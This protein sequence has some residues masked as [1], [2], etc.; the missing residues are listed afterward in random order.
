MPSRAAPTRA[1]TVAAAQAGYYLATG[2]APLLSR[3]AFERVT[4]PKTEWWLVV[5]VAG[6]VDAIGIPL[7][8]AAARDRIEPE[9]RLT[10]VAAA[11]VLGTIDVVYVAR[12]RISPVYLL[13]AAAQAALLAGWAGAR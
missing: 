5:T 13:D 1:R 6:L 12:R 10:A 8:L 2:I 7:A 3:R 11:A 9:V 4:G